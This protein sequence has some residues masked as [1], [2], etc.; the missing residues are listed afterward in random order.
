MNDMKM[1]MIM[2]VDIMMNAE[3]EGAAGN[4]SETLSR[5]EGQREA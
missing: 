4:T 1:M 2:I 3:L 5:P